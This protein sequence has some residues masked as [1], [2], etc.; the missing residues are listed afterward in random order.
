[1]STT[2]VSTIALCALLTAFAG[3][4]NAQSPKIRIIGPP[5]PISDTGDGLK[6]AQFEVVVFFGYTLMTCQPNQPDCNTQTVPVCVDYH[7]VAETATSD[8]FVPVHGTLSKTLTFSEPGDL[9]LGLI[10]V[11]IISDNLTE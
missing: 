11:Q 6:V 8:D 3:A 5:S 7:T 10:D 4:A 9:P 1:M 2:W